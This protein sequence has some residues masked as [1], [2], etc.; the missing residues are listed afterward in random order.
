MSN[1]N[2]QFRH[3][4]DDSSASST[5]EPEPTYEDALVHF[6]DLVGRAVEGH[7][8]GP[9]C[10]LYKRKT[11]LVLRISRIITTLDSVTNAFREVVQAVAVLPM[12]QLEEI[13]PGFGNS[14]FCG[15]IRLE[16]RE[17][18]EESLGVAHD[19]RAFSVSERSMHQRSDS[20]AELPPPAPFVP[21]RHPPSAAPAAS[22]PGYRRPLPDFRS[23]DMPK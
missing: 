11:E 10:D 6:S 21:D 18:G 19:L 20:I 16:L 8:T 4:D 2:N 13:L 5:S 15:L 9:G 7:Q 22:A 23:V 12:R 3:Q 1:P 14:D 17:L